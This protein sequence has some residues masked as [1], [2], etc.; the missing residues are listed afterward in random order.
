MPDALLE[1]LRISKSF[2]AHGA[3][4][5]VLRAVSDVSFTLRP[6]ETLGLVGESGCGKSTLA[7]LV[8]RL[9]EPD[10]GTVRLSGQNFTAAPARQTRQMRRL[11]Q[12]V[13]Q[14]ALSSLNP[15]MTVAINIAEPMRLQGI[16]T[17]RERHEAA[18]ELLQLVGLRRDHADRYPHE[19]S[20]GQCQRVAIARALILRPRLI[21]FDEAV[22]AL[23]VSIRAQI[24][25]LILDLQATFNLSYLFISHDLS[26]VNRIADRIA[27]M[28][29]GRIVELGPAEAIYRAP[30]HPYTRA[31]LRA[32]PV[33]DP[34]RMRVT[35]LGAIE[36]DVTSP[37]D[38]A[39]GCPFR[40]RCPDRMK[41]C[42]EVVPALLP[43][44]GRH[45]VACF[46]HTPPEL[47]REGGP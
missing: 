1:V 23:D 8:L 21:V 5:R 9:I 24:L 20:G 19:F 31:L 4:E 30:L 38:A 7:R 44:P 12:V 26:V 10:G 32:I 42:G 17:P 18:L 2:P 29:L 34:R 39:Q 13:F 37:L 41:V 3:R 14:D 46:L 27:V 40:T 28:Y 45:E 6:G 11:A 43:V 25:R 15:R 22:S 36:G 16:G 33:P 47:S 35:D